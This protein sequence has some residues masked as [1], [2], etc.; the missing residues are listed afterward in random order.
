MRKEELIR[1]KTYWINIDDCCAKGSFKGK[2][3]SFVVTNDAG[4]THFYN[5][6]PEHEENAWFA[7]LH[8][9]TGFISGDA[10]SFEVTNVT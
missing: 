3:R 4:V 8:F 5:E 7:D 9:D 6:W 10:A 2:F 1:G